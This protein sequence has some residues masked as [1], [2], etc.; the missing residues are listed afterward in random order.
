MTAAVIF[1]SF[2]LSVFLGVPIAVAL[3]I[4]TIVPVTLISHIPLTV[5]MQ[6]MFSSVDSYSLMAVPFYIIA[7][8]FLEKGGVS[9]RLVRF[10][11][12]LVGWLPG[13][14]AVVTFLASAFFGAISGSA[15][16]TVAAIGSILY[17]SMIERGYEE[18]FA[19]G[20]ICIG[21]ILGII[22]PPSIPMVLFGI[23]SGV[24]VSKIFMGGFIPGL[25]LVASM[26][27]YS[28]IY[29]LRHKLPTKQFDIKEVGSSL[30][31]AFWALMMPLIILGG[32]YAGIVT[33]TEAAAVAIFYGLIVGLFIYRELNWKALVEIV[34]GAVAS[35]GQIMFICA[36]AAAFGYIMTRENIPSTVANFITSTASNYWMF[37]GMI[38]VMLLIVGTFM[39]V[40]PATMLLSPIIVPVLATYHI[41]PVV[42]AVIFVCS[43]GVGLVTPPVGM[44]LYVSANVGKVPFE[45]VVS[46]H[47]FIYM[48]LYL[49][50]VVLLV[51]FPGLVSFI[52]S[53]M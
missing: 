45:K 50:V 43:L 20:T 14:L 19:L 48:G 22:I 6:K 51:I 35:S 46:K 33:P 27:I 13:G 26:S 10:A 36:G 53:H 40:A 5:V 12:S 7:G 15:A 21:G 32:I 8:G 41:D 18:Q 39:E 28:V 52:P 49:L 42:F 25:L 24:D 34:T 47:L 29:G 31:D 2:L 1:G 30:K 23:S 11:D 17:P 38:I 9:R 37:Y 44:N 4:G 3:L 16:A